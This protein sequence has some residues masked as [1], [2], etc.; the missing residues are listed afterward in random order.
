MWSAGQVYL[1]KLPSILNTPL[2]YL[3]GD[4][5]SSVLTVEATLFQIIL[6]ILTAGTQSNMS[7]ALILDT[8][9][10]L[11]TAYNTGPD[12]QLLVNNYMMDNV[13]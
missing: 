4:K 5:A 11:G 3:E 8:V 1:L 12:H 10:A 2:L 6:E 9:C 7:Y 13:T